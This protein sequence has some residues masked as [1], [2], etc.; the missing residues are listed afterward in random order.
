MTYDF[1]FFDVSEMLKCCNYFDSLDD[2]KFIHSD[3]HV[4]KYQY[5]GM[6]I[7]IIKYYH[8]SPQEVVD[9][10]DLSIC[11]ILIR[12]DEIYINKHF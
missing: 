10:F 1:Y 2:C 9:A 4:S 12:K 6:D 8:G 3:N 7:D 5:N 11:G